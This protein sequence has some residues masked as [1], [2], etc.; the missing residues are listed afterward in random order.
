MF[1]NLEAHCH[2]YHDGLASESLDCQLG[3]RSS[4]CLGLCSCRSH[5]WP[6]VHHLIWHCQICKIPPQL[7]I[8]YSPCWWWYF[9]PFRTLPGKFSPAN[10]YWIYKMPAFIHT[11]MKYMIDILSLSRKGLFSQPWPGPAQI[12]KPFHCHF[13]L[14]ANYRNHRIIEQFG[15]KETLTI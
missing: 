11:W 6:A 4:A 14:L 10:L 3:P 8:V 1:K 13:R 12:L 2:M 9:N 5:G 7:R 15:L